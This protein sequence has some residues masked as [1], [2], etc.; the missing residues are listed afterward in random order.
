MLY[1]TT[2][3]LLLRPFRTNAIC[4]N[5]CRE[6]AESIESLLLLLE[7]SFGLSKVTYVMAYC[8]Y[9]AATVV[10]QDCRDGLPGANEKVDTYMRALNGLRASCPG[11]SRSIDIITRWLQQPHQP[12]TT[13]AVSTMEQEQIDDAFLGQMPT[14]PFHDTVSQSMDAQM[15]PAMFS[16][17]SSLFDSYPKEWFDFTDD[18]WN[19]IAF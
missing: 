15:E 16:T 18:L 19:Q 12:V 11:I 3:I 1:H 8:A 13:G 5:A 10:V 6:A 2:I 17:S 4:R 14:F 7:R 9:T